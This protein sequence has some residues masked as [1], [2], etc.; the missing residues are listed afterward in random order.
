MLMMV[1]T[2][3]AMALFLYYP[4]LDNCY[5]N[6]N[7][8]SIKIRVISFFNRANPFHRVCLFCISLRNKIYVLGIEML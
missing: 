5:E 6:V 4:I 3:S 8:M 1:K 7:I 2:G